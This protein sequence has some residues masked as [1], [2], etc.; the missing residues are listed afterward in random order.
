MLTAASEPVAEIEGGV[1]GA[2]NVPLTW[3]ALVPLT[4]YQFPEVP[5]GLIRN[6]T[7]CPAG[8]FCSDAMLVRTREKALPV[9]D[10][11]VVE[12]DPALV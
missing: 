2:N 10:V 7:I 4:I 11:L 8:T 9:P 5:E 3:R 1:A 6:F 12:T